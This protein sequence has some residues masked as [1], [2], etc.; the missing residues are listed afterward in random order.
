MRRAGLVAP[1]GERRGIY[2]IFCGG[3]E[4]KRTPRKPRYK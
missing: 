4:G 1:R 3:L 2:R